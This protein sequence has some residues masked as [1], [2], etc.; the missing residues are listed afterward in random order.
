MGFNTYPYTDLHEMNLDWI[1]KKVKEMI[2]EWDT[3]KNAWNALKEFVE[4]YF[5]NLDVQ[6]EINNKLDE[7]AAGGELAEL[8]Q[9]YI[10][11][12]LP[13]AV[14]EQIADV[15]ALQI[16]A[17]VEAQLPGVVSDQ[18]PAVAEAAAAAEVSDWLAAHIDPDTG[19]VIDDTLLVEGAAAD[20]KA[21]GE[22]IG[23][24]SA[25]SAGTD[26]D[27]ITTR[28]LYRLSYT[29]TYVNSPYASEASTYK[30]L[31][32]IVQGT[33]SMQF[34]TAV[35]ATSPT[36]AK[37]YV[38]AA[39]G[40]G[41]TTWQQLASAKD[42]SDLYTYA[43]DGIGTTANPSSGTDLNTLTAKG[44]YRLS[45][46]AT[47]VNSPVASDANHHKFIEM[48]QQGGVMFQRY[49]IFI[50]STPQ[51]CEQYIRDYNVGTS[52]FGNWVK[53][54]SLA[55]FKELYSFAHRSDTISEEF[56][57]AA[58]ASQGTNDGLKI[59]FLTY[60]L[61][62]YNNDTATYISDEK[63][64]NLRKVLNEIDADYAALQED[65]EYIDGSNQ[66]ASEGFL[67]LPKYPESNGVGGVTVRTKITQSNKK[68]LK[69][70]GG[71]VIRTST[72]TPADGI[73]ILL[74]SGHPI[75]NYNSTGEDS[76]DTIDVRAQEYDDI[77]EW[78]NG[79]V[80]LNDY[81]SDEPVTVPSHTHV[82]IGMDANCITDDDKTNLQSS[83]ASNDFVLANGGYL[84]WFLTEMR[85]VDSIDVI[86]VSD[87]VIINKVKALCSEYDNLYSDHVPVYADLTLT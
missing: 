74:I 77:F 62:N 80:T 38:R 13:L 28:G 64:L 45:Y 75:R 39:T 9:P 2:A 46:A 4:T 52:T 22:R 30:W 81:Y 72:V 24:L 76:Q 41:W 23:V 40:S 84:G 59:R 73:T 14:A 11:E 58:S 50:A 20:A 79:D 5:E 36:D 60:N 10:D 55:D 56:T 34:Y 51:N 87:N 21:T 85:N 32:V 18:L 31:Q 66:N 57:P 27:T 3:T 65:R 61:A 42:F 67:F 1:L 53:C 15:V 49:T 29:G 7:M 35:K 8:M 54:F 63:L 19:Y 68:I 70:T 44:F 82:I 17:V 25:P 83:A 71:R 43:H 37:S 48:L 26:L 69:L 86:A 16:G 6:Q 78:A 12:Q 33:N 47:Y